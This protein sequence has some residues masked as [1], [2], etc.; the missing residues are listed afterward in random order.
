MIEAQQVLTQLQ[1]VSF[2]TG[3]RDF[4]KR[5]HRDMHKLAYPKTHSSDEPLTMDKIAQMLG[6][7]RV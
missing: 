3:T 1:V 7:K 4:K 6:G 5:F 2:P